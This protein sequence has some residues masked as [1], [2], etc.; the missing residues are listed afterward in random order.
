MPV[1]LLFNKIEAKD[2]PLLNNDKN[3]FAVL[4]SRVFINENSSIYAILVFDCIFINGQGGVENGWIDP[5]VN[6]VYSY[7]YTLNVKN[8][9]LREISIDGIWIGVLSVS[10]SSSGDYLVT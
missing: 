3:S 4:W 1:V 7:H 9:Q 10:I 5:Q 2:L 8:Y 6:P